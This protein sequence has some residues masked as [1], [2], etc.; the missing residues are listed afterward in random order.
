MVLPAGYPFT[1][2]DGIP[3]LAAGI[4]NTTGLLL[5]AATLE[6]AEIRKLAVVVRGS[7]VINK[8][9]L[10]TVDIAGD[11]INMTNFATRLGVLGFVVRTEPELQ[12]EQE[13]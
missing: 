6:P 2:A 12:A 13:T 3:I 1:Y 4:A 8:D 10:P 11:A 9:A 7:V 5:Q